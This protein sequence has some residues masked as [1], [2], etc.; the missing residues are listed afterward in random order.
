MKNYVCR[1]CNADVIFPSNWTSTRCPL[2]LCAAGHPLSEVLDL[3][4]SLR[5]IFARL[6]AGALLGAALVACA[7]VLLTDRSL[8]ESGVC[9]LAFVALFFSAAGNLG[10]V[11]ALYT[12]TRTS[13]QGGRLART[14][15]ASAVGRFTVTLL[16]GIAC[17]AVCL[18]VTCIHLFRS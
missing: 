3:R 10:L 8:S 2:P 1:R 12:G 11:A 5:D 6:C 18:A 9:R 7:A 13:A 16:F 17:L 14:L 15:D 4:A